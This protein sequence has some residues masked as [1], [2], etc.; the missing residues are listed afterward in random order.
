MKPSLLTEYVLGE[1]ERSEPGFSLAPDS[2]I[3]LTSRI[4]A[5]LWIKKFTWVNQD[6]RLVFN[7]RVN[8]VVPSSSVAPGNNES[9]MYLQDDNKEQHY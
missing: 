8:M 2:L 3:W 5:T 9:R 6:E 4:C 1:N 7:K